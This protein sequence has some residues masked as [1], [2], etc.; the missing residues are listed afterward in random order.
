MWRVAKASV[1]GTSHLRAG[2]PC[3]D[4]LLVDE[5]APET[6]GNRCLVIAMSDGAGS[7]SRADQGAK[8]SCDCLVLALKSRRESLVGPESAAAAIREAFS[9][10]REEVLELAVREAAHPQ[11]YSATLSC[12]LLAQWGIVVAQIGD[13]LVVIRGQDDALKLALDCRGEMLNVT[14]VLTQPNA[15]DQLQV[16]MDAAVPRGVVVSTDGLIPVLM[17]Q[18]DYAPHAPM[19]DMLFA[20]VASSTDPDCLDDHLA[21]LL[22]KEAVNQRTDDDKSLVIAM[23]EERPLGD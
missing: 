16:T 3:Q 7:A 21:G 5:I 6:T 1:I 22:G 4:Y 13:G 23:M 10:A 15:L 19:L 12:V 17:R 11:D 14:D 8:C 9:V 2:C 20:T 18:S